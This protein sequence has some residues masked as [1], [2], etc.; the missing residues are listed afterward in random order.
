MCFLVI[1]RC[2]LQK[3]VFRYYTHFLIR[4]FVFWYWALWAVWICWRLIPCHLH[5][6][7]ILCPILW[8]V[9]CLLYDF[10][11]CAKD[12]TFNYIPFAYFCFYFHYSKR[13][14]KKDPA[15]IYVTVCSAYIL[16]SFTGPVLYL[17][18]SPFYFC[19]WC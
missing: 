7:Q 9:V 13:W 1:C 11:H 8:V 10:L 6:L 4:L 3:C 16:L 17:V 18:F 5:H 12:F 2:S 14:M 15:V 19:V